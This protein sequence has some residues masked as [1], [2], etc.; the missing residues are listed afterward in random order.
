MAK[1]K[2]ISDY[3]EEYECSDIIKVGDCRKSSGCKWMRLEEVCV[4][5]DE[6]RDGGDC[7]WY[8]EAV[9]IK[10]NGAGGM[11]TAVIAEYK[12]SDT[13]ECE[14]LCVT[15]HPGHTYWKWKTGL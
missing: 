15:N 6:Y 9:P 10:R 11:K 13:C 3:L 7:G 5:S 14:D 8:A 2:P 1:C 4:P 12:A